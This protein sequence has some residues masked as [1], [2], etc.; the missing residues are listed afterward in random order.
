MARLVAADIDM[1]LC[2]VAAEYVRGGR[3]KRLGQRPPP[4]KERMAEAAW[5][6]MTEHC[7]EALRRDAAARF[8]GSSSSF[9]SSRRTAMTRA[10]SQV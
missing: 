4:A 2:R 5:A 3:G 1:K 7:P 8:T 6:L 9:T 10:A